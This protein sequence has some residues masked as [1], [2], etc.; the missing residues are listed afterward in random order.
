MNVRGKKFDYPGGFDTIDG[1]L[2]QCKK[3]KNLSQTQIRGTFFFE[4]FV[5]PVFLGVGGGSG[6]Y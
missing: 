6:H 1:K 3:C 5:V 4:N 2:F